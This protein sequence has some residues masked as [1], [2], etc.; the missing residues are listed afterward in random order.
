MMR[1]NLTQRDTLML[2]Q[3]LVIMP[4][5]QHLPVW[6]VSLG[7]LVV[8]SQWTVIRQRLWLKHP[9]IEKTLQLV[10]FSSSVVG[11]Y[12]T[13]GGLTLEACTSFLL[14]CLITKLMEVNAR[15]DV[16]VVLTFSLFVL[17]SLFLFGQ[18][19]WTGLLV[20]AG[21]LGTLYAMI[22]QNDQGAGRWRSLLLITGQAVPLL[23]ILFLF[24]PRLPPLWSIQVAGGNAKTGMS[25][26]MSPGDLANL[27]QSTAL[28]F[29]VMFA[30]G[31]RPPKSQLYWRGL[32]FDQF[33]G[34]TWKPLSNPTLGRDMV[35]GQ[36]TIPR[37]LQDSVPLNHQRPLSY[38]LTMEPTQQAWLFSLS[39][40]LSDNPSVGLTGD[41]TLLA[42]HPI[43]SREAL[44]LSQFDAKSIDANLP[45]WMLAQSLKLPA[46][47]NPQSRLLAQALYAR[48]NHN[49]ERYAAAVL[50]WIRQQNFVYTLQPPILTGNRIDQFLF[51]TRR[52]FCEHYASAF[53]F[54]M[55]AAGVP[56]RVVVGYQGG[57]VGQDGKSW[58]VRQLDAHAW[59]EIWLAGRGWVRMDPTGAIAPERIEKGMSELTSDNADLFGEGAAAQMRYQQFKVLGQMRQWAD[60]ANYLWQ[61]DVVGFDQAHQDQ[62]LFDWL[63]L[64]STQSKL[65]IMFGLIAAVIATIIGVLWWRRRKVWHPLDLPVVILSQRLQRMGLARNDAEGVLMWLTRLA[66]Q[67]QYRQHAEHM[68]QVYAA[69]RYAGSDIEQSAK[70][71]RKLVNSWP[72]GSKKSI[73]GS[74]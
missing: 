64:R 51:Q 54:L 26:S 40:P 5:M 16:Y 55:R 44:H 57:Q 23:V 38:Q 22:A 32:V 48:M 12:L 71:L 49:P 34:R 1:W 31:A 60:Y 14:L 35:W 50:A 52:G 46:D 73:N 61:R 20:L 11:I 25:D 58:E 41:Y 2:V 65:L 17:A 9:R 29:R 59:S 63:G 28:A 45:A 68:A 39:V 66:E 42:D 43:T 27:G 19:L 74:E 7:V 3:L 33:D 36:Q 69:S 6:L 15:R 62:S 72:V 4:H 67:P 21:V 10:L 18:D 37:W 56:A 47:S 70:I 30:D 53:T 24:F 8:L 13:Y